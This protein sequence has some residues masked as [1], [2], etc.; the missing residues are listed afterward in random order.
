MANRKFQI[1]LHKSKEKQAQKEK[2][3]EK[4][5]NVIDLIAKTF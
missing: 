3:W 2:K 1:P 4:L 5:F